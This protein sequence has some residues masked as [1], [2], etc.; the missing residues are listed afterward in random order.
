[1]QW[2]RTQCMLAGYVAGVRVWTPASVASQPPRPAVSPGSSLEVLRVLRDG[3]ADDV[4]RV[5]VVFLGREEE[6]QQVE[7]IG[8]IPA[9]SQGPLQLLHSAG[10]LPQKTASQ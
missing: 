7:G 8:I 5:L 3:H 4:Q 6:G 1:M 2:A 9:Q 10:D